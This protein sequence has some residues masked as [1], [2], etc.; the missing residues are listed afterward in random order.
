MHIIKFNK[1]GISIMKKKIFTIILAC[2]LLTGCGAS[3]ESNLGSY[4][5]NPTEA[6]TEASYIADNTET[7]P[8]NRQRQRRQKQ[9]QQQNLKTKQHM[10]LPTQMLKFKNHIVA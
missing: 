6:I 10:K 2:S 3:K 1:G 9:R 8:I 7:T 5:N 4:D